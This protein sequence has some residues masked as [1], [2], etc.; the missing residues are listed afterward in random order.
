MVHTIHAALFADA[1]QAWTT[2]YHAS[3]LKTSIG[4]ELSANVIAGYSFP[5]TFTTG[6]AWGHDG[7]GTLADGVT[8]YFRVGKA[9]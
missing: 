2:V 8:V 1:G 4:A 6:A 3:A 7:S 5:F 9:F